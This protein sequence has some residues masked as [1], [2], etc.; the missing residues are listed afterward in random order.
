MELVVHQGCPSS[1][2][3]LPLLFYAVDQAA[4]SDS[5][6]GVAHLTSPG[7]SATL[8]VRNTVGM[9]NGKVSECV[10]ISTYRLNDKQEEMKCSLSSMSMRLGM[11]TLYQDNSLIMV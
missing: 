10:V 4:L 2:P 1:S 5:L 6:A 8:M 3:L 9:H 7:G 11:G